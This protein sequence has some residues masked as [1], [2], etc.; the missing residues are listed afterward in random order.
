MT[1]KYHGSDPMS[2][3]ISDDY[4]MLQM[5][6]RFGIALGFG[7]QTVEETCRQAD[8]HL[9]TFLT[10]VNYLKYPA[11]A[12]IGEMV[13]QI[14][15]TQLIVYLK[16]SHSYFMDFRLPAIRRKLLEAVDCAA[17]HRIAFLV[18]RFYDEFVAEVGRHMNY[19]NTQVHPYVEVLLSGKLPTENFDAVVD[20]H[21]N[22]HTNIEKSLTELKKIIIK[23][24]P[25]NSNANLLNDV[26]MDI[27]MTEEDLLVH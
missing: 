20:R 8:V 7:N 18:L 15:L 23:Y 3:V 22:N 10:V 19:E 21:A 13:R 26:L 25:P 16:N 24:Y 6:G 11:H 4:R 27:Y 14:D 12:H 9:P 17:E 1:E 2:D 5:M